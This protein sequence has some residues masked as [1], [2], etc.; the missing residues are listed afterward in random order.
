MTVNVRWILGIVI[1]VQSVLLEINVL[2]SV[3]QVVVKIVV[4]N[5]PQNATPAKWDIMEITVTS[6]V[7]QVVDLVVVCKIQEIVAHVLKDCMDQNVTRFVLHVLTAI[8]SKMAHATMGVLMDISCRSVLNNVLV[9]AI[10]ENVTSK[11]ATVMNVMMDIMV[12]HAHRNALKTVIMLNVTKRLVTAL[13]VNMDLM[14]QYAYRYVLEIVERIFAMVL[15]GIVPKDVMITSMGQ[16]VTCLALITVTL[17]SVIRPLVA[18]TVH[19]DIMGKTVIRNVHQTA[20]MRHV[21]R[22]WVSVYMGVFHI[23]TNQTL[24]RLVLNTIHIKIKW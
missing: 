2:A 23:A 21:T 19:Q 11:L 8:V 12:K 1:S 14:A 18:A 20:T 13:S 22:L 24:I 7:H 4:S 15:L 5:I 10:T 9:I 17:V 6:T 3:H 16:S